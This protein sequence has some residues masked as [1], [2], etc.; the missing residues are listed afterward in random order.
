MQIQFN[1]LYRDSGNFKQFGSVAFGNNSGIS[2]AELE[3]R[4]RKML[5]DG[6]YF[7]A[8]NAGVPNLWT[9]TYNAELDHGWHEFEGLGEVDEQCNIVDS[10]DI[11]TFLSELGQR[12]HSMI[13]R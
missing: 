4:L 10:R 5:I 3:T 9:C 1:Y 11:T 7:V 6:L 2:T 12:H 8:R 13:L